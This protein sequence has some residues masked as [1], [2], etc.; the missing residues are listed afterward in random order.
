MRYIPSLKAI[1]LNNEENKLSDCT[2]YHDTTYSVT[3]QY[4]D[5][6]IFVNILAFLSL[7]ERRGKIIKQRAPKQISIRISLWGEKNTIFLSLILQRFHLR[8]VS[9]NTNNRGNHKFPHEVGARKWWIVAMRDNN[10][11]PWEWVQ[12]ARESL[13]L[14]YVC[15]LAGTLEM[16]IFN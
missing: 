15:T 12:P 5:V 4:M 6:I 11:L 7:R 1:K 16:P 3:S 13:F 2:I 10:V 8:V 9:L 14:L